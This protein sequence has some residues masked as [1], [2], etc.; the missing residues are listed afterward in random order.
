[1]YDLEPKNLIQCT[2][3]VLYKRYNADE[4]TL[5]FM[6]GLFIPKFIPRN[7]ES[8]TNDNTFNRDV[9]TFIMY[10]DEAK[11]MD[12]KLKVVDYVAVFAHV[13]TEEH[14]RPVG[15]RNY[16]KE[17]TTHFIADKI[18]T[19]VQHTCFNGV[20]LSGEIIRVY[21]NEEER[22]RFY[23][24]TVKIPLEDGT[25]TRA[26]FVQFDPSMTLDPKVG[27]T[28]Y[29]N[30]I[31]QTKR[32]REDNGRQRTLLSVVSRSIILN[33][34]PEYRLRSTTENQA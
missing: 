25:I 20:T 14:M 16:R 1:M 7:I 33:R 29:M 3:R 2:G 28:V 23:M 19:G 24:I 18:Y 21:K 22:H 34:Q 8:I 31:I 12:A 11:K 17:W 13:N 15:G 6:L 9:P 27:D 30:G 4:G 32:V 5:F 26:N 10:G